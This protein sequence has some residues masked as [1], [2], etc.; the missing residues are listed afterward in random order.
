MRLFLLYV[1]CELAVVVALA[2]TVGLGWTLLIILATF[3]LGIAVAGSQLRRQLAR[4]QGGISDP[5]GA[6]TDSALVALGTVLVFIPGLV[7]TAVGLLML[8]PPTRAAVRPLAG[9]FAARSIARRVAFV[10]LGGVNMATSRTGRGEYIDGEVIDVVDN[11]APPA[12]P[13]VPNRLD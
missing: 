10:D 9:A 2:S 1:V 12:P 4:L 5:Q 11:P 7:T 8:L 13:A 6:V 3:L